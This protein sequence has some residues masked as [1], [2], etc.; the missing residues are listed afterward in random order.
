M[1]WMWNGFENGTMPKYWRTR[2][3]NIHP[4]SVSYGFRCRKTVTQPINNLTPQTF[5][6]SY[7]SLNKSHAHSPSLPCITPMNI[8]EFLDPISA[9]RPTRSLWL[10]PKP[11]GKAWQCVYMAMHFF[12]LNV[13]GKIFY[14]LLVKTTD[15]ISLLPPSHFPLW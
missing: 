2:E 13:K 1:S 9:S 4:R 7:N 8:S 11:W 10:L 12:F 5:R 6:W 15:Y 14:L 3:E